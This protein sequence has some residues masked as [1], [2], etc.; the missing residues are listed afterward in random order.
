MKLGLVYDLRDDYRA[1]GYTEE[2]TAEF[3][4]RETV[5]A[6][7]A[8]IGGLGWDVDLIGRGQ[9]LARRLVNG[10]RFDLV[11]SIAEGLA[12]RSREAQVPALC[13]MFEQPYAFSDP[14]T[15]AVTLDKPVAKR[16]VRDFGIPTASFAVIEDA[17]AV[18]PNISFPAF[19]KPIA[20]GTGK[21]CSGRS[22]VE[23]IS[24]LRREATRLIARFQQPVLLESYLPGREFTVGIIGNGAT[25]RVIA[26]LEIA[27]QP[28]A[29]S[30]IY[31]FEI[32]ENWEPF[33]T[34]SIAD[35]EEARLAGSRALAAYHAL[36]C[37]DAARVDLKSDAYSSPQFLEI[38]PIAGLH[39][40]HSDLPILTAKAGY[41]F[42][43]LIGGI[44]GAAC[45]RYNMPSP[46]E[47]VE[48]A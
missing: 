26:V 13:E 14:L 19:L 42:D 7:S 5:D 48:A 16:I 21:G 41:G 23:T 20:E 10:D 17:D 4:S 38:N 31:S 11:F 43:W 30:G 1:L 37:R 27:V 33:V 35:D 8:S 32:K 29:D 34:L 12:G 28:E 15:M 36:G 18:L 45:V 44:I 46:V 22:R 47:Q 39:P 3:D 24:E 6:L 40:T 9:E 2:E 25:A